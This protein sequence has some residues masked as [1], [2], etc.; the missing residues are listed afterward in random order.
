MRAYDGS[1]YGTRDVVVTVTDVDEA[2]AVS[3]QT[4]I[5]FA[6]NRT[7]QVARYTATDPEGAT[8]EWSLAGDDADVFA[9][10]DGVLT[11]GEVPDRED[12]V[13]FNRDNVYLVTV[14]AWDGNSYGTRDVVVTVTNVDE[15]PVISVVIVGG[16]IDPVSG[17]VSRDYAEDLTDRSVCFWLRILRRVR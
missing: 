6:E 12:P 4:D 11:F 14:R 7:G 13:D 5:D 1:S 15:A 2:P 10:T 9:I 16:V 8:V 3:G 17:E